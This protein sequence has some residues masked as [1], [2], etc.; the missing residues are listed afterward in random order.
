MEQIAAMGPDCCGML[1]A[2]AAPGRELV[3]S[4]PQS[5]SFSA[6]TRGREKVWM[7]AFCFYL[8][9]PWLKGIDI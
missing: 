9:T 7:A 4:A 8:L 5:I 3:T 1:A 2:A 6:C